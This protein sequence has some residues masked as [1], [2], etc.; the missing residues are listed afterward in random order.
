MAPDPSASLIGDYAATGSA[1]AFA[2][3]V[4]RHAGLVC[5][6]ALRITGNAADA[7]EVSQDCFWTMSR[8]AAKLKPPL[9]PWLHRV[10]TCR[11][12]NLVRR[13]NT[14]RWRRQQ[15]ADIPA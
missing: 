11:A 3:L 7:E 14:A 15:Y 8:S 13:R 9:V 6:V 2:G 12:I 10:A 5:A 4:R 1:E